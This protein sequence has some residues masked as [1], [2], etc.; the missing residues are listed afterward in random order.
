[1]V[2]HKIR[3]TALLS[4]LAFLFGLDTQ[5]DASDG[6]FLGYRLGDTYPMTESTIVETFLLGPNYVIEAEHPVK[7]EAFDTVKVAAS[8]ATHHIGGIC[9]SASFAQEAGATSFYRKYMA[10]LRAKYPNWTYDP[11]L[12][13]LTLGEYQIRG[14][15]VKHNGDAKPWYVQI[16]LH[17]SADSRAFENWTLLRQEKYEQL[18]RK[19]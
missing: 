5:A 3:A 7:P 12:A 10:L 2:G 14:F 19:L 15:V 1:M 4:V 13:K 16:G 9:G 6:E 8:V 17:Y 18:L 11:D